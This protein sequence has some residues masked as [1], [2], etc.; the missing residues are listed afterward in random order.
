MYKVGDKL[1]LH[2]VNGHDYDVEIVNINEFRPPE[3]MYGVDIYD[4]QHV[5]YGDVYF[6]GKEFLDK[7]EVV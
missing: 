7:C 6:C 1:V 4:D 5:Y 2:S 3:E